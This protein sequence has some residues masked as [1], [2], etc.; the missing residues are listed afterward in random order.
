MT[1][2]RAALVSILF[3]WGL[4]LCFFWFFFVLYCTRKISKIET[5]RGK[6]DVRL[7]GVHYSLFLTDILPY[8]STLHA[9]SYKCPLICLKNH[10]DTIYWI[11][12]DDVVS[13]VEFQGIPNL[14]YEV[15]FFYIF[16]FLWMCYIWWLC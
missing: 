5:E 15:I 1:N 12:S 6:I 7:L 4:V 11:F 2:S 3:F 10:F 14:R 16:S 9:I 8:D 13:F